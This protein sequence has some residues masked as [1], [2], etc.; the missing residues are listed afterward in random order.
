MGIQL[1][2]WLLLFVAGLCE[3]A[4]AIGLKY[5]EGFSRLYPSIATVAAMGASIGLLSL[6]LKSI[7]VGTAYVVWTGIGAAGTVALGI[8]LFTEPA[9]GE[10]SRGAVPLVIVALPAERTAIGKLQITLCPLHRLDREL[11]VDTNHDG[12]LRRRQIEP[13]DLGGLAKSGS[14]LS[15]H[16]LRAKRSIL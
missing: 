11:F 8:Y 15:H 3:V 9:R 1:M 10:Q 5:T 6:A 7:P 13:A 2:A 12:V 16:D 4:W 14:L